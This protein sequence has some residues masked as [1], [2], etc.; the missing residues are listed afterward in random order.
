MYLPKP[1][2][3]LSKP[4]ASLSC[5]DSGQ[6]TVLVSSHLI[7]AIIT[8][9]EMM[10]LPAAQIK[11]SPGRGGEHNLSKDK[12]PVHES[13]GI[14]SWNPRFLINLYHPQYTFGPNGK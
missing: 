7:L 6:S 2:V 11:K 4:T 13:A 5:P 3:I 10:L 8:T 9:S 1:F 14:G 12:E